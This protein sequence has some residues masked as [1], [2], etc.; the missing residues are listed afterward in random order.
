MNFRER[1]RQNKKKIIVSTVIIMI[2]LPIMFILAVE[3]LFQMVLHGF[4]DDYFEREEQRQEAEIARINDY[5]QGEYEVYRIP[6]WIE[7]SPASVGETKLGLNLYVLQTEEDAQR[8]IISGLPYW[9]YSSR[10]KALRHYKK[11]PKKEREGYLVISQSL[12]YIKHVRSDDEKELM[13]EAASYF[14]KEADG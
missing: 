2:S 10:K 5:F 4:F 7:R 1:L 8:N 11:L 6:S 9:P 14:E 13:E 3:I 12:V